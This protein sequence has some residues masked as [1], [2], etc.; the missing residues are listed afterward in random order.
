MRERPGLFHGKPFKHLVTFLVLVGPTVCGVM[1]SGWKCSCLPGHKMKNHSDWAYGCEPQLHLSCNK[2]ESKFQLL[3]HVDF[4]GN[5]FG[6]FLNYTLNHYKDICLKSCDCKA[7]QYTLRHGYT[8]CYPK[9]LLL[10]GSHYPN[11]N[12]NIYLK[13][14]KNKLLSN[15]S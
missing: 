3:S 9:M 15:N 5:D 8:I 13:L 12:G 2:N 6:V 1:C 10:N 4:Y 14:P 11:L 7:F